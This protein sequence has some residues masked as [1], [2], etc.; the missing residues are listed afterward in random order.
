MA[1][2]K[3]SK[4]KRRGGNK[5]RRPKLTRSQ[6]RDLR[7]QRVEYHFVNILREKMSPEQFAIVMRAAKHRADLEKVKMQEKAKAQEEVK[8]RA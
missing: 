1:Y 6:I 5:F 3:Q 8:A 7:S 4:F 2:Q